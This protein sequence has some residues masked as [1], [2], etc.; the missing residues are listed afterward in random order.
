MLFF[1]RP[2]DKQV[3]QLVA[4]RESMTFWY[5]EVG[6]TGSDVPPGYGINHM[7]VFLGG[8]DA[9]RIRAIKALISQKLLAVAGLEL[10]PKGPPMQPPYQRRLTLATFRFLVA[11]FLARDRCI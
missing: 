10:H 11:R 1:R 5:S 3:H 6:G 8:G 4:A 7:R 2:T 9:V